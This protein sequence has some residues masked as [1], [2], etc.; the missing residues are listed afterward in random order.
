MKN[1]I[2]KAS[3]FGAILIIM[4]GKLFIRI[5]VNIVCIYDKDDVDQQTYLRML[6]EYS[7]CYRTCIPMAYFN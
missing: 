2:I 1:I 7:R 4:A 3:L 5:K 6:D